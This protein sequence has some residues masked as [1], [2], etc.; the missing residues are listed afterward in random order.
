MPPS[1]RLAP[2]V[3][4]LLAA[5]R[6]A[7]PSPSAPAT[8][9]DIPTPLAPVDAGVPP[10]DVPAPPSDATAPADAVDPPQ[11]ETD[12]PRDRPLAARGYESAAVAPPVWVGDALVGAFATPGSDQRHA[13]LHLVHWNRAGV[14][15]Q[16]DREVPGLVPGGV[17]A[18]QMGSAAG[19]TLVWQG[20]PVDGG[21]ETHAL[22]CTATACEAP[23]RSATPDERTAGAW[24]L[25]ALQ[26]RSRE[27]TREVAP[28]VTRD[29]A[30]VRVER[31]RTVAVVRLGSV[32]IAR[33]EDV[34]GYQ[35]SVAVAVAGETRWVALSRGHCAENRVELYRVTTAGATRVASWPI[36]VEVGVR[37]M[38]IEP[39][40]AGRVAVSWY[41]DLIPLRIACTRGDGAPT[42]DD[43]GLRVGVF[44]PSP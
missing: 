40:P 6:N 34:I 18:A 23:V 3:L 15:V 42:V 16:H 44:T 35:R 9:V 30:T 37:W 21:V 10:A 38:R 13:A 19:P 11:P 36:G 25:S 12:F 41:Q 28:E 22:V 14:R 4:V 7:P 2:V 33:S 20:S 8:P 27:G 1:H 17:I 39:H 5:C 26:R 31:L 32:E 43:H 29:G 24:T